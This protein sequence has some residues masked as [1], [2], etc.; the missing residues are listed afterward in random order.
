MGTD[1]MT[2]RE[3]VVAAM[4]REPV[5]HVPCSPLINPLHET[6]RR[7]RPW[8]FPWPPSSDGTE[9]LANALH[10]DP[11]LGAWWLGE[12]HP[13][14]AVRSRT[15]RDGQLLH[16]VWDTPSGELHAA[17]L[18]DD[19]WPSGLDIPFFTDF[20]G[21]FRE[22]W[23]KTQKDLA[24]LGHILLP[25]RTSQHLDAMRAR[26]ERTKHAAQELQ[27]PVMVTI[28]AGLSGALWFCGAEN[29]CLLTK[30]DPDLVR[31]YVEL[32]HRWNMRLIEIA[33][34]WGVDIIRR[35]SFYES[36][37]YFSPAALERFLG[38]CLRA[39]VKAVR[40]A[41]L[42]FAYIVH[43]GVM[44][45]LDWLAS[46]DFDCVTVLD[47]AFDNVDIRAVQA[48]L[49]DRKSFWT[50]PSNTFHMYAKDPE[51]V[52]RAVRDVFAVFGKAGLLITAC[53]STHPMMPW[54]NTL[55]MIDEWRKLR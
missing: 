12:F 28:G 17:V 41:G 23:L 25:P 18:F 54:E 8:N 13:E 3:R 47:I 14:Q 34:E 42:P 36:A 51:V 19:R 4:K 27:A 53:S 5:D 22:P 40:E 26:F 16:K 24:C 38:K 43:S 29:V 50:G 2:S 6:Q 35:H 7:G 10:V 11:V 39:E 15:W 46:V 55:A 31:G 20:V 30:D 1:A 45:M 49:G 52:R 21:H 9:Y 32:E 48:R 37:F 33:A 44:P